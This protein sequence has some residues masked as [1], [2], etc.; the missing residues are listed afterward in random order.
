[1]KMN[2]VKMKIFMNVNWDFGQ[3]KVNK[4]IKLC[5]EA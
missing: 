3:I 4:E 1:M 2:R 5:L